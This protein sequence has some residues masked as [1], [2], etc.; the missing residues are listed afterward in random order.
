MEPECSLKCSQET[1][2]GPY[3]QPDECSVLV[4]SA[5][6]E[7]FGS[8]GILPKSETRMYRQKKEKLE[9]KWM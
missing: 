1:A 7:K 6:K 2:T 5:R 4:S 3:R 8:A 9:D